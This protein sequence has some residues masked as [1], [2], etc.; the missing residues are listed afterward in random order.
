MNFNAR[1]SLQSGDDNEAVALDLFEQSM[2]MANCYPTNLV[3]SRSY[4]YQLEEYK[5][6][7]SYKCS[8]LFG[9]ENMVNILD[10]GEN[11]ESRGELRCSL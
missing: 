6:Q 4:D 7:I 3:Y 11:S 9:D 10:F 8:E 2:K 1:L 5:Q